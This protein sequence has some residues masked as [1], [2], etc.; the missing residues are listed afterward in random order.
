M[1]LT[2]IEYLAALLEGGLLLGT[3]TL[4][5]DTFRGRKRLP[6]IPP[7]PAADDTMTNYGKIGP[8]SCGDLVQRTNWHNVSGEL[9]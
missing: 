4:F 3:R 9:S 6:H 1:C 2:V 5:A 8:S 7:E